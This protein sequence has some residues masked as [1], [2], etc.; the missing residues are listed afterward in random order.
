MADER[1]NP[2]EERNAGQQSPGRNPN[3]GQSTGQRGD[4]S[5]DEDLGQGQQGN[6]ERNEGGFEKGG[7]E[8]GGQGSQN[9]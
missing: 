4:L 9:R 3:E 8:R 5:K 6:R 2:N 7:S 1:N